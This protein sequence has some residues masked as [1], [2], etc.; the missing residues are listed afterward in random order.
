MERAVRFGEGG[1]LVG[2]LTEPETDGAELPAI[3]FLN[4]GILHH[5]GASR[6]YVRMARRLAR[7]GFGS[8]RFDFAGVG[9]S[10]QRHDDLPFEEGAMRDGSAALDFLAGRGF[11][12]FILVGLCSGSDM[13][14]HLALQDERIVGLV[15]LDGWAY[16]T[17]RYYLRRYVPKLLDP[18]AW[19]HSIS[20]RFGGDRAAGESSD[21]FVPPEYRRVFPPRRF[22]EEGMR[23]LRA[24]GVQFFHYF[25]GGM[26]EY[27]N[28]EEQYRQIFPSLDLGDAVRVLYRPDADHTVTQLDEQELVLNAVSDWMSER[29]GGVAA[30]SRRS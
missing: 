19:R 10:D 7:Q 23:S 9:D 13:G 18:R 17:W 22:V 26:S 28:Y 12:R 24:R 3:V 2:V 21:A 20:V 1:G 25:T 4:S 6:L 8:L 29:Y 15:N 27:V 11:E 5:V 14:F 16:R 30:G